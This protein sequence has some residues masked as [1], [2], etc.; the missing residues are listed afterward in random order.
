MLLS[1]S[2]AEIGDRHVELAAH[3]A[4]GVLGEADGAWLANALQPR[5]DVDAIA[6]KV[7]VAFFNDVPR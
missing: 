6:H 7:A 2:W 1:S 3:L 4:I 5:G